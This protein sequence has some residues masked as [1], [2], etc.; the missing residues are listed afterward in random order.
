MGCVDPSPFLNIIGRMFL[1]RFSFVRTV[2]FTL[3][4]LY[5]ASNIIFAILR[6][7]FTNRIFIGVLFYILIRAR[8]PLLMMF[9]IFF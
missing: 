9:Y 6:L 2:S 1:A 7:A 4:F 3:N 5:L 8:A